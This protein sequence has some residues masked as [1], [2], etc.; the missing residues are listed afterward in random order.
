[1][2]SI[3]AFIKRFTS[4]DPGKGC[5]NFYVCRNVMCLPLSPKANYKK[6]EQYLPALCTDSI[7]FPHDVR[8][9]LQINILRPLSNHYFLC[10]LHTIRESC[11]FL[12]H[13]LL[14]KVLGVNVFVSK[15][16]LL[17][18]SCFHVIQWWMIQEISQDPNSRKGPR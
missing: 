16:G 9:R 3:N 8:G 1:M 7:G 4:R 13:V 11:I 6:A 2:N 10:E 12:A 18:L 5:R 14:G 15:E 17:K